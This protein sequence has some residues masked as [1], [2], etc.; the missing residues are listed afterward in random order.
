[1]SGMLS[2]ACPNELQQPTDGGTIA[3]RR[4]RMC[5]RP[6]PF[7]GRERPT[8]AFGDSKLLEEMAQ[9]DEIAIV[10]TGA[11]EYV[12]T[13]DLQ[14]LDLPAAQTGDRAGC[15]AAV[16]TASAIAGAP[17]ARAPRPRTCP[18]LRTFNLALVLSSFSC[19]GPVRLL[20]RARCPS[21]R[22]SATAET[23][24]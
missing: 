1:M 13:P 19:P 4:L 23:D 20:P 5:E 6:F 17:D 8:P 7:Q 16:A 22:S 2:L 12:V 18:L 3:A 24:I 21:G 14:R 9:R 15:G 11:V 10:P